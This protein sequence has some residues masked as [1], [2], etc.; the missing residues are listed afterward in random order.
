MCR[1]VAVLLYPWVVWRGL[2]RLHPVC[3][4]VSRCLKAQD[5]R[6]Q[7]RV[8][9]SRAWQCACGLTPPVVE[10]LRFDET[11]DAIVVSVRPDTRARSRCGRCGRRS[12]GSRSGSTASNPS[13]PSRYS[14]S[15][16]THHNSQAE[17]DPRIEQ[18][19]DISA[20]IEWGRR[21]LPPREPRALEIAGSVR[22]G[23]T[24]PLT[25]SGRPEI[26]FPPPQGC[27]PSLPPLSRPGS[28]SR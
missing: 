22:S 12:P 8:Q 2:T 1:Y 13:S 11:T 20:H 23:G 6:E 18:K 17:T 4:E 26:S 10:G 7:N 25:C 21:T 28:R 16:A 9:N 3:S 15:A 27:A 19:S 24:S 14:P 5:Q